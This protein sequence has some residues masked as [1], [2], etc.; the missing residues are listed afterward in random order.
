VTEAPPPPPALPEPLLAPLLEVAATVLRALEAADVPPSMRKVATFDRRGLAKGPGRAQLHRGLEAVEGFRDKVVEK[1]LE[2]PEVSSILEAWEPGTAAEAVAESAATGRLPA[3]AS[4]LWAGRPPGSDFALGLAVAAWEAG[5]RSGQ[6]AE[7]R[8]SL[9]ERLASVEEASRR[10]EEA[11]R[12]AEQERARLDTELKEERKSRKTRERQSAAEV[13]QTARRLAELE[14]EL[15][16]ARGEVEAAKARTAGEAVRAARAEEAERAARARLQAAESSAPPAGVSPDALGEASRM[17]SRLAESLARLTRG[18]PTPGRR[19]TPATP[20]AP[21]GAR[22][23]PGPRRAAVVIPPGM[24]DDS[25]EAAEAMVRTPGL[26]LV[27]DGYNVSM[28][29]WGEAPPAE[30]RDRLCAALAELQLRIRRPVTIVFDGAEV[31]GV[32]PPRRPGLKV[33]FSAPGQEADEIVVEE[34]VARP[35]EVPVL[36]VSSDAW[37]REHAQAEG[38]QVIPV[39]S[40]LALLRR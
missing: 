38:A 5:Q 3:L 6:E 40:L 14:A 28:A 29:A 16:A 15:A 13:S 20:S 39:S 26:D 7:E 17:A 32:R 34:V 10:A 37:V 22:H 18:T 9:V 11:R 2:K 36:V 12:T 21:P 27:V 4:A 33:L 25:L 1:F 24:R 30:Q 23:L 8:L 35:P 31:E 19:V